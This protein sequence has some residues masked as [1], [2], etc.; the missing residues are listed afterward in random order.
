MP[1]DNWN[2]EN[3][4]KVLRGNGVVVMPTDTLYGIVGGALIEKTVERIYKAR[5]R[6]PEKPCIILIGKIS[7]LEKFSISLS[8]KQKETLQTF[9]P[10]PVSMVLDCEEASLSYLHR[11]TKTLAFRLPNS[12]ELRDLLMKTGPLV[13][14]SAN[15]EGSTPSKNIS[16]A[17]G[18]FGDLVDLYIDGGEIEG[19]ASKVIRLHEDGSIAV[20]RE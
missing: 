5:E 1:W 12:Q 20:L 7:E 8:E 16:E 11:G 3:L 14:P 4:V 15:I 2:N 18:Y 6:N 10:V 9:Q 17:R 13:A 19:K